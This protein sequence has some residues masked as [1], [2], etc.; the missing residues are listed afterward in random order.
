[1]DRPNGDP[2][3]QCGGTSPTSTVV[4][5]NSIRSIDRPITFRD[6]T[7]SPYSRPL[8]AVSPTPSQLS[9]RSDHSM[10]RPITFTNGDLSG[11]QER[12]LS[13]CLSMK[14]DWSMYSPINF[15]K[16]AR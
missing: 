8:G 3:V 7:T 15:G 16:D 2:R 1:M 13:P 11:K 4:S 12:M 14:S 10:D 9:L 5:Q 6:R